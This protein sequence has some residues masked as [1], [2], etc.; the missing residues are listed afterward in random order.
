MSGHGA[1][2]LWLGIN[3][4]FSTFCCCGKL[5]IRL[6]TYGA[7]ALVELWGAVHLFDVLFVF[8]LRRSISGSYVR[9]WLCKALAVFPAWLGTSWLG[10]VTIFHEKV[11]FLL[12]NFHS[13][14]KEEVSLFHD[15]D[16]QPP[17]NPSSLQQMLVRA[18]EKVKA[19][20]SVND[21]KERLAN[22]MRENSVAPQERVVCLAMQP[23][24]RQRHE[25][26]IRHMLAALGNGLR[27]PA[28]L[29]RPIQSW[30]VA[31]VRAQP[32]Y[33][34]KPLVL[35]PPVLPQVRTCPENQDGLRGLLLTPPQFWKDKFA[36]F[37]I[38]NYEELLALLAQSNGSNGPNHRI[39]GISSPS[40]RS[41]HDLDGQIV[42]E[43]E[44]VGQVE[45]VSRSEL[46]RHL[47]NFFVLQQAS[48]PQAL[49]P[50]EVKHKLRN[51]QLMLQASTQECQ[52]HQGYQ[53]HQAPRQVDHYHS[54]TSYFAAQHTPQA[55]FQLS[56]L[57]A[58][59]DGSFRV[60][61]PVYQERAEQDYLQR[62]SQLSLRSILETRGQSSEAYE[63]VLAYKRQEDSAQAAKRLAADN[64]LSLPLEDSIMVN[65]VLYTM[66]ALGGFARAFTSAL[67]LQDV[68][69]REKETDNF[70]LDD[71][72]SW[73][74]LGLDS[75]AHPDMDYVTPE[76]HRDIEQVH[77]LG[78]LT[79]R[80]CL[81]PP[82]EPELNDLAKVLGI[83]GLRIDV[84][85]DFTKL[86]R[87]SCELKSYSDLKLYAFDG[88]NHELDGSS[89][90]LPLPQPW[91]HI[92][93]EYKGL[94]QQLK[95]MRYKIR[96]YE[97]M[98]FYSADMLQTRK[99]VPHHRFWLAQCN[100]AYS[101]LRQV[102]HTDL[103]VGWFDRPDEKPLP[104]YK[105][106]L[107][108]LWRCVLEPQDR[109]LSDQYLSEELEIPAAFPYHWP[110]FVSSSAQEK[111]TVD[112]ASKQE[113]PETVFFPDEAQATAF[114]NEVLASDADESLAT[115]EGDVLIAGTYN[116]AQDVSKQNQYWTE[117]DIVDGN[118]VY[119]RGRAHLVEIT[120][121]PFIVD[122]Y[123]EEGETA[124]ACVT[125]VVD[126]GIVGS[127]GGAGNDGNVA[128]SLAK[129]QAGA[130]HEL[131]DS[132]ETLPQLSQ[133]QL[134]LS[135]Q[136]TPS[137]T[138]AQQQQQQL[139]TAQFQVETA[140]SNEDSDGGTTTVKPHSKS[141]PFETSLE[142][143]QESASELVGSM[144]LLGGLEVL[145]PELV[146]CME[147]AANSSHSAASSKG[148]G[149][150]K[151][152]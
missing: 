107:R 139:Q 2:L 37:K 61:F 63:Q 30:V 5:K 106:L 33:Q 25:Q 32:Q 58:A 121:V 48:V 125:E 104:F 50:Q 88:F 96:V 31:W 21:G 41:Q 28:S 26:L 59:V 112:V 16:D 51:S 100:F 101:L 74:Q 39:S 62:L 11:S 18:L 82:R 99:R 144:G 22:L 113:Q 12:Q 143:P 123:D 103:Y 36:A 138:L 71:E 43:Q 132:H 110:L 9:L 8:S 120:D 79:L 15:S 98:L 19:D 80:D 20:N 127:A 142:Q 95:I 134:S 67:F 133:P 93:K 119:L 108:V 44:A 78:R 66:I 27:I 45:Q 3:L 105:A 91:M 89:V 73:F 122:G 14:R 49:S 64:A 55:F 65:N 86:W 136:D 83:F 10:V 54:L 56:N 76:Q 77:S 90:F 85:F 81:T 84:C 118:T 13:M 87:P 75:F 60:T 131:Q 135:Q 126:S 94:L 140:V 42:S 29:R 116:P 52:G 47:V 128:V 111:S 46:V 35:P 40:Q 151:R 114:A 115:Y 117:D 147:S 152:K 137:G 69:E 57:S 70:E 23:A 34:L 6:H 149:R 24:L 4:L 130:N 1:I 38:N 124:A 148:K 141:Q 68:E 145:D 53:E 102:K 92:S 72:L 17:K 150:G 146:Q 7:L 97:L 109:G 129:K